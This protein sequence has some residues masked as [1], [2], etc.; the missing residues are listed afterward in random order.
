M[1]IIHGNTI[2]MIR[3]HVKQLRENA[4]QPIL[5]ELET[6]LDKKH[7]QAAES[8]TMFEY[9]QMKDGYWQSIATTD[10]AA[11]VDILKELQGSGNTLDRLGFHGLKATMIKNSPHWQVTFTS[12]RGRRNQYDFPILAI[13][14]GF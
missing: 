1:V 13:V 9:F 12:H 6:W 7:D 11:D 5:Q 8:F 2:K 3:G 4:D 10:R 14:S